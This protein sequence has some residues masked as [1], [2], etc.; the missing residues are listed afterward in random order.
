MPAAGK[1]E[2]VEPR[3]LTADQLAAW[4]AFMGLAQ[5]LPTALECQLQRDSRLSFLE[6]YVLALLSDQ[7]GH[8]MRMSGLAALANAELSRLSHLV[9]R[10]EKRC[11]LRR[12][13]DPSDGRY[14]HVILTPAGHDHLVAAAPGHVAQVRDL[15]VD[16]LDAEELRTL[17][18]CAEKVTA[19]IGGAPERTGRACPERD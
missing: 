1:D 5:Q 8:R 10:L 14:T 9:S 12:E 11:I 6:Y 7:P 18:R 13:P 3:W 15:F 2:A 16:A 4:R 17:R 19:R